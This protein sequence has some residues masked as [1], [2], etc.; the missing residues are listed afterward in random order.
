MNFQWNEEHEK[1]EEEEGGDG[2]AS[3]TDASLLGGNFA[4][5]FQPSFIL[6]AFILIYIAVKQA[7]DSDKFDQDGF[8]V[9]GPIIR[10]RLSPVICVVD[11]KFGQFYT[12][13]GP[14]LELNSLKITCQTEEDFDFHIVFNIRFSNPV[15][16]SLE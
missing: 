7:I 4:E 11:P 6:H 14:G 12:N 15:L 2:S 5:W 9:C 13:Q 1:E 8:A 16:A 10:V 3:D